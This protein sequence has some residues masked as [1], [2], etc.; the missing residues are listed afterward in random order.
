M[1]KCNSCGDN[2]ATN[3]CDNCAEGV[4]DSCYRYKD[5]VPKPNNS[6][7]QRTA[8]HLCQSCFDGTGYGD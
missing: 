2:E 3:F 4:C 5:L 6:V 8:V 7:K 1:D